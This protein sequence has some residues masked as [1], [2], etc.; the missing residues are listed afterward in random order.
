MNPCG[1]PGCGKDSVKRCAGDGRPLG[2]CSEHL[3]ARVIQALLKGGKYE[4]SVRIKRLEVDRYVAIF[5]DGFLLT[6]RVIVMDSANSKKTFCINME[7]RGVVW[8][9]RGRR[10]ERMAVGETETFYFSRTAKTKLPVKSAEEVQGT[11]LF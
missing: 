11:P 2:Q 5:E 6:E 7:F 9:A 10:Y 8:S 4:T 3:Q 1:T